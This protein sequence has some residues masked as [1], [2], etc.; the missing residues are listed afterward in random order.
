MKNKNEKLHVLGTILL[1]HYSDYQ[2]ISSNQVIFKCFQKRNKSRLFQSKR[3]YSYEIS[4]LY[5]F[6]FPG[7]NK[8]QL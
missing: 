1:T 8:L 5:S 7:N 6:L 4:K 3:K 2:I